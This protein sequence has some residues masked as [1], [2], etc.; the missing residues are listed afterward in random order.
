MKKAFFIFGLLVLAAAAAVFWPQLNTLVKKSPQLAQTIQDNQTIQDLKQQ[1]LN[2]GALRGTQD[3][4][5]AFLTRTGIINFTNQA[6]AQNGNLPALAE[7]STLDLD[8]Q[9]KLKDMFVRQYFEHIS[10]Q[11]I[12]PADQ[13]KVAGYQYVI[14]GENLALGNFKDDSALVDA[15]MTSPGHRANI[16]NVKY[17]EMGAAAGQGQFEG[18]KVWLAV[19]EFGKPLS[20]CPEVDTVLKSQID[21]LNSDVGAITPQLQTLKQQIGSAPEPQTQQQANQ[22]NQLISQYN[23][24]ANIYNNKVD[25]LKQDIAQYNGEVRAFNL[26][27]S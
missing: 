12:G 10:P 24:L 20:S 26:C 15:W 6:R 22:Y 4:P 25:L 8:A 5:D 19:Q 27:A 9:N 13:A 11:G 1:V 17:M 23:D 7:N 14:I 18:K 16:L 2:G 3:S 21:S